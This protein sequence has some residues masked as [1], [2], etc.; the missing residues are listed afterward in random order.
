V[1]NREEI[2]D[3]DNFDVVSLR[4]G[5]KYHPS[6]PTETVDTDPN[7]GILVS[8]SLGSQED[9]APRHQRRK[10]LVVGIYAA[11]ITAAG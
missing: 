1:V 6:D 10:R 3:R 5:A 9:L 8:L 4:G 11:P 7:H 2:I